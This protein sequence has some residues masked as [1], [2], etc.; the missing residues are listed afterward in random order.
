MIGWL[1]GG[2]LYQ[3]GVKSEH[4]YV[5][6]KAVGCWSTIRNSQRSDV[7]EKE[8]LFQRKSKLFMII[9]YKKKRRNSYYFC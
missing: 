6:T 7:N 1:K 9:D 5:E 2:I 8:K 4:T 3:N